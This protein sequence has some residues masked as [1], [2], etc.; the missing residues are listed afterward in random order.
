MGDSIFLRQ[1]L[2]LQ[3]IVRFQLE[4]VSTPQTVAAHSYNVA[5]LAMTAVGELAVQFPDGSWNMERVLLK[6]LTHDFVETIVGDIDFHVKQLPELRPVFKKLEAQAEADVFPPWLR[7]RLV[8]TPS[9]SAEVRAIEDS[10]VKTCDYLEFTEFCAQEVLLGNLN[11]LRLMDTGF[12]ILDVHM[13]Q[14]LKSGSLGELRDSLK[15]FRRRFEHSALEAAAEYG[16][17][18]FWEKPL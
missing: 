1:G 6:A 9:E 11:A 13:P 5:L 14:I 12:R 17:R 18:L 8:L 15:V 16:R 7:A 10:I 3:R 4:G 2:R